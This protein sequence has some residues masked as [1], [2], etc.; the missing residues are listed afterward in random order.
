MRFASSEDCASFDGFLLFAAK[1][2]N[3][4]ARNGHVYGA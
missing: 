1:S 4:R 3:L 2:Q